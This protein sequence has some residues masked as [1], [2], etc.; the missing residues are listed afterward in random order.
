MRASLAHN[1]AQLPLSEGDFRCE[2]RNTMDAIAS[3]CLHAQIGAVERMFAKLSAEPGAICL[4]TGGAAKRI[5]PHLSI[6]FQLADNLILDGL[7]R[8]GTSQ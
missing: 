8:F 1:T 3:G 6:P 7:V 5:S 4:L 2:P